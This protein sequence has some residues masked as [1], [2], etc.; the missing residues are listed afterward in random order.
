MKKLINAIL[1]FTL[2]NGLRQ[3]SFAYVLVFSLSI[4]FNQGYFL[5][6]DKP[7]EVIHLIDFDAENNEENT[8]D[9]KTLNL[10]FARNKASNDLKNGALLRAHINCSLIAFFLEIILRPPRKIDGLIHK[11]VL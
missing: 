1:S 10:F 9:E 3:V 7:F 2:Q 11:Y 8:E 6:T 5:S 4:I